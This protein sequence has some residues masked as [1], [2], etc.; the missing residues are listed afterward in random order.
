MYIIVWSHIIM[1][2]V[3]RNITTTFNTIRVIKNNNIELGV[4]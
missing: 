1:Y 4:N 3:L 2:Y